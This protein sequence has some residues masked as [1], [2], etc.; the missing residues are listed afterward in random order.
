MAAP[1]DSGSV[2]DNLGFLMPKAPAAAD[3]YAQTARTSATQQATFDSQ[4]Q[5]VRAE[6]KMAGEQMADTV[7]QTQQG[8]AFLLD[9]AKQSQDFQLKNILL[10]LELKMQQAKTTQMAAQADAQAFALDQAEQKALREAQ[11]R[12]GFAK[13]FAA[14]QINPD[15]PIIGS[16]P[17]EIMGGVKA[18]SAAEITRAQ[19]IEEQSRNEVLKMGALALQKKWMYPEDYKQFVNDPVYQK[20]RMNEFRIREQQSVM[21]QKYPGFNVNSVVVDNVDGKDVTYGEVLKHPK[22]KGAFT[23]DLAV[24]WEGKIG[25]AAKKAREE[26]AALKLQQEAEAK[27]GVLQTQGQ[28]R[29]EAEKTK[30]AAKTEADKARA[31]K[32]HLERRK[33][34]YT[35]L[36]KSLSSGPVPPKPEEVHRQ[37]MKMLE[38]WDASQR[39]AAGASGEASSE[40]DL[41]NFFN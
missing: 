25:E 21:A 24:D 16:T 35:S 27:K 31:V 22:F 41:D 39:A 9:H 29:A 18:A 13:N 36:V 15:A 7:K 38:S 4:Q 5:Q 14:R 34:V 10:P 12:D 37:A 3:L 17:S 1:V 32:D 30:T 23:G 11:E 28:I 40:A 6:T 2:L 26:A 19:T 8:M 20:T 33:Q